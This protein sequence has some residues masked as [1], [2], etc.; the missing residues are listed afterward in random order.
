MEWAEREL[1]AKTDNNIYSIAEYEG[2]YS[3]A[4]QKWDYKLGYKTVYLGSFNELSQAKE[5]AE[6]WEG[7][8]SISFIKRGIR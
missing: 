3:L 7:H 2:T 1:T 6:S 4:I 8:E 5:L